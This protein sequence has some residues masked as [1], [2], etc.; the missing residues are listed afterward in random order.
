VFEVLM[1]T[2]ADVAGKPIIG[3]K[4]PAHLAYVDTLL[5]WFPNGRVIHM[6]RDPRAVYVS[7][8]RRRQKRPESVPYRQLVRIPPA[9][10]AFVMQQVIWVWARAVDR[11]R[12]LARRYPDRY[13]AVRFEDLVRDPRDTL[14]GLF[15]FLGVPM[16][17]RV[18][19][20]KVVSK[21]ARVGQEGF[22]AEAADRWREEI[23]PRAKGWIDGRLAGRMREVGYEV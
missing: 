17:E 5:D 15:S 13:R 3:E 4:T 10:S 21:G 11:H 6:L 1:R 12:A 18:L 16:E 7:E 20:Q 2:Y 19:Q 14:E 23:T 8:L 22:D 9:F